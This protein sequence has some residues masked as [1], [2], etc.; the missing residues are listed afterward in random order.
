MDY[1][2]ISA[3]EI[4]NLVHLYYC[5]LFDLFFQV[6]DNTRKNYQNTVR[7]IQILILEKKNEIL[8]DIGTCSVTLYS[9]N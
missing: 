5:Q 3:Y 1:V 7:I 8:L 6:D 9:S 4:L 2:F